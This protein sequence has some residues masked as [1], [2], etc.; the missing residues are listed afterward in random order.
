[1]QPRAA[2]AHC[3]QLLVVV[4]LS[5]QRGSV[6][7]CDHAP[8]GQSGSSFMQFAVC[9]SS[10][11]VEISCCFTVESNNHINRE[12]GIPYQLVD[13]TA[14]RLADATGA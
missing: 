9:R 14:H 13:P 12:V 10:L 5:R 7:V 11:S 6:S 3:L 1:M 4:G 8:I 2:E